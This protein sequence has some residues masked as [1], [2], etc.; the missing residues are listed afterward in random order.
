[1]ENSNDRQIADWVDERM[2]HLDSLAEWKPNSAQAFA[3]LHE[4]VQKG[5]QTRRGW[6]WAAATVTIGIVAAMAVPGTRALAE[7]CVGACNEA[8]SRFWQS[9]SR[10]GSLHP[11]AVG[12]Q[13]RL[14]P[15]FTL[16]ESSGKPIRLSDYRGKVVLLNFWATWCPPCKAEIPW[17]VEFQQTYGERNLVV[18][19][20]SLDEDGWASV[21]PFLDRQRVTYP[22]VIGNEEVSALYGGIESLP[23]TLIIDQSGRIAATH[24]GLVEKARYRETIETLLRR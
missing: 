3:H 23:T 6:R 24:T 20:V 8:G 15:D 2:M 7:R 11:D 13:L 19:G 21:R 9:L 5:E 16:T 4:R 1:M 22:V 18:L 12:G 17:F 14:A 10:S